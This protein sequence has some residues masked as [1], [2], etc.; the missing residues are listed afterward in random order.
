MPVEGMDLRLE[1]EEESQRV[2]AISVAFNQSTLQL[3]AFAAPKSEGLW[4]EVRGQIASGVAAQGGIV[5][6]RIGSFGPE[7]IAQLPATDATSPRRYTRFIGVDGPRWMLRGTIGGAAITDPASASYIEGIFKSLVVERGTEA[8][9]PRDLL[10]LKFPE[11]VVAP[12]PRMLGGML[13]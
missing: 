12:P 6:E 9:P 11:G 8:L 13:E 7:L 4:H 2:L 1:I 3:Q 5:E 10:S